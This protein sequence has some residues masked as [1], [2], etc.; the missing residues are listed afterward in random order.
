MIDDLPGPGTEARAEPVNEPAYKNVTA[1]STG[2]TT[3]GTPALAA[4]EPL[5]AALHDKLL[6]LDRLV[7]AIER[8]R[9]DGE[10]VVFTNGCFDVIHVG[11]VSS[12]AF[13]RRFGD[14]VVVGLNT[15]AS[16]RAQNKGAD[17]PILDQHSRMLM[18]AALVFVDYVV[19]F[20]EET[21][22][23]LLERIRP[24]VLIKGAHHRGDVKGS[25]LVE[26]YGGRIELA[27]IV[28][29]QSTTMIINHIRAQ[30]PTP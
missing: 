21:P 5:Q 26:S 6:S 23:R 12:L 1:P 3:V 18:L 14:I 13:C 30:G 8:R 16:I 9:A 11:H 20:D 7:T 10:T 15:D 24:D 2:K 29:S 19:W 25:D 4:L 28:E 27:P 17:R 22:I